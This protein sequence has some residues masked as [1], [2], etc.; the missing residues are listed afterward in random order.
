MKQAFSVLLRIALILLILFGGRIGMNKLKNLKKP[1]KKAEVK[2]YALSVQVIQVQAEQV[3]VFLSGYGEVTSRSVITLPAEVAGRITSVHKELQIGAV[4]K[5][6]DILYTIN[7]QDYRLELNSARDRLKSLQRDLELARRE[8][9]RVQGLYK[10]NRVGTQSSVEQAERAVN[11]MRTQII[12]AKQ[13]IAQAELHLARCT[14]RAPFTGRVTELY[15]DADEYVA[16]GKNLLTLVND[17]DLEVQVSLDSREAVS[18]LGFQRNEQGGS[19]FGL[20]EKTACTVSWTENKSVCARGTLDRVVRFD[21]KTRTLVLAVRI[22]PEPDAAVPLVQGMFCRVGIAGR[23]LDRAFA[24]PQSAVSFEQTVYV[25]T[26]NRLSTRKVE[27]ARL[28]D[29]TALVI[30]GLE[31]GELVITTR[32]ENPPENSSVR[33]EEPG[34]EAEQ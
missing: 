31:E 8:Y 10:K 6:G 2:E 30:D 34:S 21:P 17:S 22:Q 7:K 13:A 18:W 29:G 19:W 20:P 14:V 9:T 12:Q 11:S 23:T 15:T 28:Q 25:V 4:I 33:I 32:L 16:P 24:L 3:P 26:D 27:V 5:K 1:P